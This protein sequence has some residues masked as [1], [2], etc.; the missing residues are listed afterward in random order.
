[1]S[2]A[3]RVWLRVGGGVV[4]AIGTASLCMGF[5]NSFLIPELPGESYFQRD[6]LLL[7]NLPLLAALPALIL[8]GSL[9]HC[10]SAIRRHR[11]DVVMY[12][13]GA[14]IGIIFLLFIAGGIYQ[15]AKGY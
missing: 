2:G 9:F 12:C 3:Q 11:S 7:G 15:S 1:M 13:I 8:A 14:A 10:S 6:R 5:V 4:F